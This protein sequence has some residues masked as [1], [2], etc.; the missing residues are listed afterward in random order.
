M[1]H[2]GLE[3]LKMHMIGAHDWPNSKSTVLREQTH[4]FS[5]NPE[6]QKKRDLQLGT[7]FNQFPPYIPRYL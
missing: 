4:F 1:R 5:N 6:K 2:R 7:Q 3:C